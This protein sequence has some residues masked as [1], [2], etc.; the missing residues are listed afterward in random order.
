MK[1]VTLLIPDNVI[2]TGGTSHYSETKLLEVT[3]DAF[4]KA[5][6]TNDY[7][8]NYYFPPNSVQVLSIE[9]VE[10]ASKSEW[11]DVL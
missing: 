7:H 3:S 5:L 9:N 2:C 6:T 4:V 10:D 1:K 8:I 11:A